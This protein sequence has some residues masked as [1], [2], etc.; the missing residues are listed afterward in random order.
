MNE[1]EQPQKNSGIDRRMLLQLSGAGLAAA[2]FAATP[3]SAQYMGTWDKVF[4]QSDSVDHRK[5]RYTNRLGIELVADMYMPRDLDTTQRHAALIVG[6]PYGGVKEQTAGLY[7]QTM[8]ERG[9]VTIAHDAS[10][11]GES[12]GQPHF[13]SS[14]EATVEDFSAGV[15]F[16]GHLPFVDRERIGVIGVCASGGYS[17]AAAQ[18]DPRIK[19]VATVSMYDMGGAKWAWNGQPLS[20]EARIQTLS[21]IG[22]QRWAEADGDPVR[23]GALPE[24]LAE[25]TDPITREFFDYYRTPRGAHPR[26]T[27]AMAVSGDASYLHFRPFDHVDMISPRPVLLIAGENA[28]SLFFSEQAYQRAAEPKE[29]YLVPEAGHVD[30]YDK[31]GIIPWDKLQSF[32]DDNLSA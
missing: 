3:A 8:A 22:A 18:I 6:H 10:F 26:A 20:D 1:M 9:F 19:A 5:V 27:T 7:A 31:V 21:E 32:F 17:L 15:D 14:P 24:V 12:G 13:I 2:T 11:N 4:P 23:Y 28:H 30:L 16:L 29:L 25:D